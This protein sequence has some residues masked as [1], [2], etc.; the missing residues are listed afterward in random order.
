VW[1]QSDGR[2]VFRALALTN[3]GGAGTMSGAGIAY[4]YSVHPYTMLA[5]VWLVMALASSLVG[6]R[7]AGERGRTLSGFFLGLLFGPIGIITA[8]MLP[9]GP[10]WEALA[11]LHALCRERGKVGIDI[12]PVDA[13]TITC[14]ASGTPAHSAGVQP[15]DRLIMIDGVPCAG[16]YR[17]MVLQLVGDH[18]T[19]VRIRVRRGGD[20]LDLELTRT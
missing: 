2:N 20:A 5:V 3:C 17:S 1:D 13:C 11:D 14:V 9:P 10:T 16:D 6:A 4:V 7:L 12:D 19:S 8:L 18:N 15:G